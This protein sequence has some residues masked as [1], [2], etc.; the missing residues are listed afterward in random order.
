MTSSVSSGSFDV[1][2]EH[3]LLVVDMKG[4]SQIPEAQMPS[5]RCD[6][7]D[8][9]AM[10][11][12][13]SGLDN[14]RTQEG[15]SKDTGDGAILVFPAPAVSRLVDPVLG[16][17]NV[18]LTRYEQK[19]PADAPVIRLRASV[20]VGP[21]TLP[22]HRG[23]AIND[24]CRLI[25]SDAARAALT[26][27][28]DNGGFL[29]AVV[30]EIAYRRTVRAGR[31][32]HLTPDHFSQT[33]ARVSDKPDFAQP[34]WLHVPGLSGRILRPHITGAPTPPAGA[35]EAAGTPGTAG[36]AGAGMP[37]G[38]GPSLH[39]HGEVHD[40]PISNHVEHLHMR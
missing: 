18:A 19:R 7:D 3:A 15:C 39:I 10:A 31:T 16:Q 8:I 12:A 33:I 2:P 5:V 26:A 20:H 22:D 17:I 14:P 30:S 40:S 4:Y 27:A 21:L 25:N 9:L 35:P 29:G 38:S 24:A 23:D 37:T 11:L 32:A 28:I 34:C 13:H 36:S 1:P 6:V